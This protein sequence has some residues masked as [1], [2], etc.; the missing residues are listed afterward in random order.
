ML[1]LLLLI[2]L[3]LAVMV[4]RRRATPT[5]GD[6]ASAAT[7]A[8]R[9]RLRSVGRRQYVVL[10]EHL[11]ALVELLALHTTVLEPDLD[12]ALGEVQLTRDLPAFLACD[13]RV[14]DEL[15]LEQHRLVPR[16]RLALLALSRQ[17]CVD[18]HRGRQHN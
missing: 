7:A 2:E 1:L 5:T 4:R 6:A 18:K 15:V 11:G 17:I 3:S 13:V 10:D 14:A 12:L 16:V 8:A 9:D